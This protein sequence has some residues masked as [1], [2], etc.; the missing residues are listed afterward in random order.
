MQSPLQRTPG[1]LGNVTHTKTGAQTDQYLISAIFQLQALVHLGV[2]DTDAAERQV[3]LEYLYM[4][5]ARTQ[6][7]RDDKTTPLMHCHRNLAS[8]QYYRLVAAV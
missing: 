2:V 1:N 5:G 8:T 4:H 7:Q 6:Q 3:R